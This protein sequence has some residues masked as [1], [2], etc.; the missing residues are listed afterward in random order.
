MFQTTHSVSA[1]IGLVFITAF[2]GLLT[3][4]GT[5][6][7]LRIDR[8]NGFM[9][10]FFSCMLSLITAMRT[11]IAFFFPQPDMYIPGHSFSL[12]VAP[13]ILGTLV[14]PFLMLFGKWLIDVGRAVIATADI[15]IHRN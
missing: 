9:V 10:M 12:V 15:V 2:I 1:I 7:L 3:G 14:V 5:N 11:G 13:N 8:E 6:N 4:R